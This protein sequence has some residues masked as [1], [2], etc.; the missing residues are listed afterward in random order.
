LDNIERRSWQ[1]AGARI[2]AIV[3]L[4]V[5]HCEHGLFRFKPQKKEAGARYV[6]IHSA[7]LLLIEAL[8]QGRAKLLASASR[9]FAGAGASLQSP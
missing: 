1:V 7:L 9:L 3:S 2:D 4:K 8:K 5:K 6:P